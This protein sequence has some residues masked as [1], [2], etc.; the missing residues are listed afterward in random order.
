MRKQQAD[1]N[2]SIT[3]KEPAVR[4]FE[5]LLTKEPKGTNIRITVTDPGTIY[6]D[7]KISFCP[8]GKEELDDL[9]MHFASF[10]IFVEKQA[11]SFLQEATIDFLEQ[12]GDELSVKAPHLKRNYNNNRSLVEKIQ[13][14]IDNEINPILEM[15]GGMIALEGVLNDSVAL[16]RFG[17]G[18]RGCRVADITFQQTVEHILKQHFPELKEIRNVTDQ[19]ETF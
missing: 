17:G 3:V 15:H 7:I 16:L 13:C 10:D 2:I 9:V 5:Q 19:I 14:V 6:A 4:Y 11:I 12:G 18:C 1:N 8:S